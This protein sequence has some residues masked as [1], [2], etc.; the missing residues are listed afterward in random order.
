MLRVVVRLVA[1]AAL[2]AIGLFV[3]AGTL[4]WWRAFDL[5]R[6]P[7][8]H[9]SVLDADARLLAGGGT[10]A[11]AWQPVMGLPGDSRGVSPPACS[12]SFWKGRGGRAHATQQPGAIRTLPFTATQEAFMQAARSRRWPPAVIRLAACLATLV[13]TRAP[14]AQQPADTNRPP[15]AGGTRVAEHESRAI[16]ALLD[17]V[18]AVARRRDTAAFTRLVAPEFFFIHSSGHV[19]DVPAFLRFVAQT[20]V[21]SARVLS[22]PEYRVYGAAADVVL[23][24]THSANRVPGRGWN[25]YRATDLV[26]RD[27]AS[28]AGWRWLAHQSTRLPSQGNYVQLPGA[29]LD[30]YTGQYGAA[31]APGRRTVTREGERLLLSSTAGRRLAFRALTESTFGLENGQMYLVFGRDASGRVSHLEILQR[32]QAERLSRSTEP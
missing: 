29:V 6:T 3:S 2:V 27:P 20:P 14:A 18:V 28:P 22:P 9:R 1:D 32:E 26:V 4:A 23:V 21:D 12:S 5:S 19:D 15:A 7:I 31:G 24:L 8:A 30:A 10:S 16:A 13:A 17:S 11:G 25:A